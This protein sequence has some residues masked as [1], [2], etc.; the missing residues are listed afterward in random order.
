MPDIVLFVFKEA[1][2]IKCFEL[3]QICPKPKSPRKKWIREVARREF[4]REN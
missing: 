4:V 3:L 2:E 1:G